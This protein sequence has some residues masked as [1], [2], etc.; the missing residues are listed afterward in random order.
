LRVLRPGVGEYAVRNSG[1][2]VGGC[3]ANWV[4][5][6][7]RERTGEAVPTRREGSNVVGKVVGRHAAFCEKVHVC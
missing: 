6:F 2:E 4:N 7:G 5:S 3:A 1:V